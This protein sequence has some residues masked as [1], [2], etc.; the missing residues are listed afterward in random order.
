MNKIQF[1]IFQ[2][3]LLTVTCL[4][5]LLIGDMA[6]SVIQQTEYWPLWPML[7]LKA[8][9]GYSMIIYI[10]LLWL[11]MYIFLWVNSLSWKPIE[12]IELSN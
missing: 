7:N 1:R 10:G 8:H 4:C 3:A 12:E 11:F 6:I 5:A 9:E 2:S